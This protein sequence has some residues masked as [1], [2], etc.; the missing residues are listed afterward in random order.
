MAKTKSLTKTIKQVVTFQADPHDIYEALM[1]S[2]LHSKFT[3][4]T[5]VISREV[6]GTISAFDGWVTGVNKEL[7]KNK[8]IVQKWRGSDWPKGVYSEATFLLKKLKDGTT[9]LYFTHKNVPEKFV[10]DISKGWKDFY[11]N[12][13]K[14]MLEK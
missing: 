4:Q 1:D 13:M 11:W 5:A 7:M 14:K 9:K 10:K 6:G 2:K 8:K 3:K 12:P